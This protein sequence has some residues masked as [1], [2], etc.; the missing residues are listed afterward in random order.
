ME[1]ADSVTKCCLPHSI[2]HQSCCRYSLRCCDGIMALQQKCVFVFASFFS[3]LSCVVRVRA[4]W[5]GFPA[6]QC[7]VTCGVQSGRKLAI[8]GWIMHVPGSRVELQTTSISRIF[9][10]K[11]I[12]IDFTSPNTNHRFTQVR[13]SSTRYQIQIKRSRVQSNMTHT[14]RLMRSIKLQY[15]AI[16]FVVSMA[17]S[18][19]F[20]AVTRGS[21][22]FQCICICIHSLTTVQVIH[23][24]LGV[25]PFE[26]YEL[27]LLWQNGFKLT[28]NL[29]TLILSVFDCSFRYF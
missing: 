25:P 29:K 26:T 4:I 1:W 23:H 20:V 28:N 6:R 16:L 12:C 8:R 7:T 9:K 18:C 2:Y 11:K 19:V 13:H 21:S 27:C 3:A 22:I 15:F 24:Q 10:R 5:I 17:S 14:H